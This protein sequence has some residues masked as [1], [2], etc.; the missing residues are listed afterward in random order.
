MEGREGPEYKDDFFE[1]YP[2]GG[3]R[4]DQAR[5]ATARFT[6]TGREYRSGSWLGLIASW[7]HEN[8]CPDHRS[9]T[10]PVG[11]THLLETSN[12]HSQQL[13]RR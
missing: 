9:R 2:H 8:L 13:T 4:L 3:W 5:S 12:G 10:V 1:T 11:L 7:H 6:S